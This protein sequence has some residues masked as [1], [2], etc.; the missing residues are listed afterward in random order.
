MQLINIRVKD[1]KPDLA[2]EAGMSLDESQCWSLLMSPI[3]P[4]TG[5][6]IHSVMDGD[7][8]GSSLRKALGDTH[9]C[10]VTCDHIMIYVFLLRQRWAQSRWF[11]DWRL[12]GL[13]STRGGDQVV[14]RGFTWDWDGPQVHPRL[15]R[16]AWRCSDLTATLMTSQT[17][18]I[19]L[20]CER[21][22]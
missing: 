15:S 13:S 11:E 5:G 4:S 17:C 12:D 7:Q 2:P 14:G 20:D 9:S 19:I 18:H 21:D 8:W 1:V 6:R 10:D 3:V 16:G 22:S